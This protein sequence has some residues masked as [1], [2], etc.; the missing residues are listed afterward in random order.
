M[1]GRRRRG[2]ARCSAGFPWVSLATFYNA[3]VAI[4][5][6]LAGPRDH[7]PGP[8]RAHVDAAGRARDDARRLAAGGARRPRH[9]NSWIFDPRAPKGFFQG[10]RRS[11]DAPLG[12]RAAASSSTPRRCDVLEPGP[13]L[14][15]PSEAPGLVRPTPEDMIVL[16]EYDAAMRDAVA[17]FPADDWVRLGGASSASRSSRCVRRRKRCWIPCSSATAA[18]SMSTACA[19]SVTSTGSRRSPRRP[20]RGTARRGQHT[21]EVRAEADARRR[22]RRA[23]EAPRTLGSPLDGRRRPRP[24]PCRRRA[25]RH[26]AARRP[27]RDRDQGQQRGAATAS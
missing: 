23:T 13:A 14:D 8:A 25:L 26:A 24:R 16:H 19:W 5:A 22:D 9:F 2:P 21:D 11:L 6:A 12:R 18:S 20:I 7:R 15:A 4:N 27:R 3:S 17:K 10:C 1:H